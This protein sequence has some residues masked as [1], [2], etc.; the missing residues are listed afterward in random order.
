MIDSESA[1]GAGS[2]PKRA[3]ETHWPLISSIVLLLTMVFFSRS[4]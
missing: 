4:M 1:S 2:L 3:K